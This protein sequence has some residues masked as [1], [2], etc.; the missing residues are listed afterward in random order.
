MN[1]WLIA[2]GIEGWKP[3]VRLLLLPPVPLLLLGCLAWALVRRRPCIARTL[4]LLS[5]VALW[6]VGTPWAAHALQRVLVPSPPPLSATAVAGLADRPGAPRTAIVV[7]GAGRH[8]LAPEYGGPDLKPLGRERLRYGAWLA[9]QTRLPLLYSGGIGHG[10]AEPDGPTEAEA[11]RLTLARDGGPPLRW[12]EDRSRDTN[13][14]AAF[15]VALLQAQGI[16]R[17][18][19]V[20]HDFHQPRAL[21]A[22]RRAIAR[23]GRP[24]DLVPAPMGQRPASTGRVADFVPSG[25]GLQ[26]SAWAVYE[27]LGRLAGA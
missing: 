18:V 2:W 10:A 17:I 12:S 24:M 14:N 13:E 6:L 20:T 26:R 22:F 19:L 23:G 1:D 3:A 8:A 9:R 5:L 16:A 25:E 11:A 4:G 21:A 15:S 27:W 7:L